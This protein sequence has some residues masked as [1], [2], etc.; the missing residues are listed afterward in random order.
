ML[1]KY[2]IIEFIDILTGTWHKLVKSTRL[3]ILEVKFCVFIKK[4]IAQTD[5]KHQER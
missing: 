1:N 2:S 3:K 5:G 4:N